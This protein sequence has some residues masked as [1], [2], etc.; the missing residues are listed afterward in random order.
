M[1][2]TT[3]VYGI[4]YPDGTTKAKN[5]PAELA[6]MAAGVE[7][8]LLAASIPP[9]TPAAVMVAA[10]VAARDAYWGVPSTEAER[11]ALQNRG[12]TTLRTDKGWQERYLA[13]YDATTNPAGANPAGWYRQG[14]AVTF[15]RAAAFTISNA[16]TVVA[17]DTNPIQGDAAAAT[18]AAGVVTMKLAGQVLVSSYVG[19]QGTQWMNTRLRRIRG[20][21]TSYLAT[22]NGARPSTGYAASS[23]VMPIDVLPGDRLSIEMQAGAD[24]AGVPLDGGAPATYLSLTYL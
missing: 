14:V 1:T 22:N 18:N 19:N 10:S 2:G 4:P 11:I 16:W 23:I 5:L 6:A 15:G 24:L 9:V 21:V 13:T 17:F 12:A 3:P 20:A 8:S 7:A